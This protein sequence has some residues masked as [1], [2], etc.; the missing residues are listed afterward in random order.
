MLH[1]NRAHAAPAKFCKQAI[2]CKIYNELPNS[3]YRL[4]IKNVIQNNI[5]TIT[6]ILKMLKSSAI[7]GKIVAVAN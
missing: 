3:V 2:H 5:T 7:K 1:C 4:I 6:K